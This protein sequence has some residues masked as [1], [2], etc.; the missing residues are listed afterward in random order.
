MNKGE[1]SKEMVEQLLTPQEHILLGSTPP[2]EP[3]TEDEYYK[4]DR[5]L[6]G[7]DPFEINYKRQDQKFASNVFVGTILGF[8]GRRVA[9]KLSPLDEEGKTVS[10]PEILGLINNETGE[11]EEVPGRDL[12]KE[13]Y[14]KYKEAQIDLHLREDISKKEQEGNQGEAKA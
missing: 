12:T 11:V 4:P 7:D 3:K 8:P 10:D 5:V 9:V 2:V 1:F 13:I 14:E 6:E